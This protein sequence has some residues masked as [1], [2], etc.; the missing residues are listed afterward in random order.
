[1]QHLLPIVEPSPKDRRE[2]YS[3]CLE[4]VD[5]AET[6]LPGW[7]TLSGDPKSHPKLENIYRDNVAE[8]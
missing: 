1:M 7:F 5:E 4:N 3:I 2:L 8:W 6:W